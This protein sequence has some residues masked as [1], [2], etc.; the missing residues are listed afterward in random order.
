LLNVVSFVR[1]V[2]DPDSPPPVNQ[3]VLSAMIHPIEEVVVVHEINARI[4]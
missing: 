2:F 4:I 3:D 1:I